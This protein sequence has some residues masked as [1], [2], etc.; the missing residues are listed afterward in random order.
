MLEQEQWKEKWREKL[1]TQ[2]GVLHSLRDQAWDFNSLNSPFHL[3]Y[4]T[5]VRY[6]QFFLSFG[7]LD[8]RNLYHRPFTG[9][10]G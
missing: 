2:Q 10:G 4:S 7:K 8:F 5:E 9:Q 3:E 1:L 6:S